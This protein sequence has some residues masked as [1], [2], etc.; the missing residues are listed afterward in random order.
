MFWEPYIATETLIAS[1]I[2]I[3]IFLL[4]IVLRRLFSKYVFAIIVKVSRQTEKD[5]LTRILLSFEKPV[6]W[7]FTIIGIYIA[8]VYFPYLSHTNELFVQLIKVFVIIF[9]GWGFYNLM[10]VTSVIFTRF[11]EKGI[12]NIDEIIIPFISKTLRFIILAIM[13]S[14]V[15]SVFG[16]SINGFV[17][18]LGLG[19]LAIALAAQDALSNLFGGFVILSEKPFTIGDWILTPSVEG[20][21]ESISFRSTR[22]RTFAQALVTIPNATLANEPITNWSEMGKR[23]I[24]FELKITY[25]TPA[26]R[27]QNV[28]NR[29]EYYL[30]NN[31]DIHQETIFVTFNDYKDNGMEIMLYFFTKSTVWAE[32]LE[33]REKVNFAILDILRDEEVSVAVPTRRLFSENKTDDSATSGLL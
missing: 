3:G 10:G 6:Q 11:N 33:V 2:A 27:L 22:V 30:K 16:Y 28:V 15:V 14:L 8:V 13:F 20:T 5:Y 29:I 31:K 1:S 23:R 26:E 7:L 17:A 25:D 9:I 4:F 24:S 19:G 32:H 18:G 21:V 12:F